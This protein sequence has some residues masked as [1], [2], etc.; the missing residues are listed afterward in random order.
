MGTELL[1]IKDARGRLHLLD[2]GILPKKARV[3]PM[4]VS[5]RRI[6]DCP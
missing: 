5:G 2:E 4:G 6:I 1:L 3:L